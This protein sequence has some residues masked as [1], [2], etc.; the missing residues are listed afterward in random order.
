MALDDYEAVVLVPTKIKLRAMSNN[1]ARRIAQDL[2]SPA[3]RCDQFEPV[4]ISV[5]RRVD[6]GNTPS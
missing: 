5:Q 6:N 4:V 1:E 3:V 2:A